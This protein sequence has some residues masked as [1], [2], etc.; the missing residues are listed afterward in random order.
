MGLER[1]TSY[2][3][4]LAVRRD[5]QLGWINLYVLLT[6]LYAGDGRVYLQHAVRGN[7]DDFWLFLIL[8]FHQLAAGYLLSILERDLVALAGVKVVAYYAVLKANHEKVVAAVS[9]VRKRRFV[10]LVYRSGKYFVPS[11]GTQQHLSGLV[12]D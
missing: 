9:D 5:R 4:V 3:D 2:C 12:K 8:K 6:D 11:R 7:C 1:L 10:L